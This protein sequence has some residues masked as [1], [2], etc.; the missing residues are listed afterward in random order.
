MV[1]QAAIKNANYMKAYRFIKEGILGGEFAEDYVFIETK[2]A[3]QIGISRTPVREAMRMLKSENLL[4]SVPKKGIL[5][6]PISIEDCNAIYGLGESIESMMV[7]NI[8]LRYR[9]TDFSWIEKNVI[10]MEEAVRIN[11]KDLWSTADQAFHKC[12][13]DICDN[14]FA[15]EAMEKLQMYIQLVRVR[16]AKHNIQRRLLSTM[17]HRELYEAMITGDSDFARIITINHWKSIRANILADWKGASAE[18]NND[19]PLLLIENN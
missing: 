18:R 9:E 7:Y 8:V 11:D 2:L 6:R 15:V 4:Q 19:N 5:C 1:D 10:S 14:K 16:Y 12:I 13:M 3:D 17:Q